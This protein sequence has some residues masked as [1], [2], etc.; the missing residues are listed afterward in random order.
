[1]TFVPF[2]KLLTSSDI[3][4]LHAPYSKSTHHLINRQSIKL[5]KPTALLINTARGGLVQTEALVQALQRNKL[6]G[7][8]LDVL[9]EELAITEEKKMMS[10]KT[11]KTV[12]KE[13]VLANILLAQHENVIVTPH[14]AFNSEEA[15]KR[16]L[17][18]TTD[19]IKAFFKGKPINLVK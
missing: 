9:E 16:I 1:V 2:K 18:T 10:S 4:S 7:A 17:D 15:L 12:D 19:N 6:G 3:V 13:V 11:N 14:N 8:G 5:M